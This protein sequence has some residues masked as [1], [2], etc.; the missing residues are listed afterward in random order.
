[1]QDTLGYLD[2][3]EVEI[4]DCGQK[5]T[6]GA[7]QVG[8]RGFAVVLAV[9]IGGCAHDDDSAKVEEMMDRASQQDFKRGVVLLNGV[10]IYPRTVGEELG[11]VLK[12]LSKKLSG[13]PNIGRGY[14]A[15]N[16]GRGLTAGF[17]RRI[18]GVM[19]A[20]FDGGIRIVQ[21]GCSGK[22]DGDV[23]ESL[24]DFKHLCS[25]NV[26]RV[27]GRRLGAQWNISWNR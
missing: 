9:K 15:G 23:T 18:R 7:E 22:F 17:V 13:I 16:D 21:L 26:L 12:G 10:A 3:R 8:G 11:G 5:S 25:I 24:V 6:L 19:R 27:R 20:I 14:V 2:A 1:M 4:V